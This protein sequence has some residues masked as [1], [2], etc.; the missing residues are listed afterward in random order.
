MSNRYVME[1][2]LRPAVELY[3]AAAGGA[4]TFVLV[5]APWSMALA[6]QVSYVTAAGFAIFTTIRTRQGLRILRYRRN[7]RRLPRYQMSSES[8][9][10][11]RHFLFLGKGFMWEQ[12]H[13][14]RLLETKRPEVAPFLKPSVFY[15]LARQFERRYEYTFPGLCSLTRRDSFFNPVRP[16]PPVGG[17]SAI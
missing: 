10:V 9:P 16:L 3:S 13:T 4:A 5:V 11:S 2:L 15:S 17:N 14:Q 8:I 7:I 6:P 12:K 1:A